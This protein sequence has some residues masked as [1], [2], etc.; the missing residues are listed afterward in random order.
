MRNCNTCTLN[1][2]D[3]EFY[4][5]AQTGLPRAKCIKC[6]RKAA[7]QAQSIRH[8]LKKK[9]PNYKLMRKKCRLKY[10]RKKKN[11]IQDFEI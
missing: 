2:L 8:Q 1:K 10:V 7:T 3:E 5:N 6:F 11:S 4:W 9:D